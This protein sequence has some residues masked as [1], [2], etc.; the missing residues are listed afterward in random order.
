M[1]KN[2]ALRCSG[3]LVGHLNRARLFLVGPNFEA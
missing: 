3:I 1:E 2:F